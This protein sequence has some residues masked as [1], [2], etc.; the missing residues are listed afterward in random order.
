MVEV[1]KLGVVGFVQRYDAEAYEKCCQ[2][3]TACLL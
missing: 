3:G 2:G 1:A